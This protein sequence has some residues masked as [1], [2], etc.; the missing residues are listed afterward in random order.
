LLFPRRARY[1]KNKNR[2]DCAF[3]LQSLNK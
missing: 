1:P 2:T 3:F